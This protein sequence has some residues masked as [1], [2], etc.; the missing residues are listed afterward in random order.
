MPERSFTRVRTQPILIVLIIDRSPSMGEQTG[1]GAGMVKIDA[2]NRIVSPELFRRL[3]NSRIS[4]NFDIAVVAFSETAEK[5][6][7]PVPVTSIEKLELNF[8]PTGSGTSIA[9]GL[10]TAEEIYRRYS[11]GAEA[12][13]VNFRTV[14]MVIT[15]GEENVDEK[16]LL[17]V[18]GRLK[19][20][21]VSI[22]C[23]LLP[24]MSGGVTE[25]AKEL[26]KKVVSSPDLFVDLSNEPKWVEKLRDFL[27]KSI[28]SVTGTQI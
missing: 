17:E 21:G 5:V 7:G 18:S 3:R 13:G 24:S 1:F 14:F 4:H 15:D 23:A 10:E 28:S 16:R 9:S 22:G 6:M 27:P 12:E 20:A 19:T 8:E 26:M 2:V 11:S 25:Q